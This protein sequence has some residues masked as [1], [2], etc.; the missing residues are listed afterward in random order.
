MSRD[1]K[2]LEN[3]KMVVGMC[4]RQNN[5]GVVYVPHKDERTNCVMYY[6]LYACPNCTLSNKSLV[7]LAT[8]FDE[9]FARSRW[10]P[11]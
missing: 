10:N 7:K 11:A 8:S 2:K 5:D 6:V 1:T 4:A 3:E 9:S